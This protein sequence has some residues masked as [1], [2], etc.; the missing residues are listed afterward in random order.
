MAPSVIWVMRHAEKRGDP[1]DPNLSEEGA[2]HAE[3]LADWFPNAV[4]TPDRII[5]TA[6]SKH[7]VRPIQTVRPLAA[8][9]GIQ[10]ETDYA[11]QDYGALAKSLLASSGAGGRR[12]LVCWHHGNIPNMMHALGAP[13]GSYPDPWDRD[14]FDL[15]LALSF[16]SGHATSATE[17]REPLWPGPGGR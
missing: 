1:D 4:G 17:I 16:G 2:K 9:L 15:V 8:A 11:D 12:V 3:R 6:V 13:A 7:S 14:T 10:I 5:A